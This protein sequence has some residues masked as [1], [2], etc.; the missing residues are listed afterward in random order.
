MK[1]PKVSVLISAYNEENYIGKCIGSLL[2]QTYKDMEIVVIDDGSRDKTLEIVKKYQSVRVVRQNH[3]GLGASRNTGARNARGDIIIF[4]DADLVYDKDYVKN[5]IKPIL[6]GK[7][8]GTCHMVEKVANADNIW[9]KNWGV[10]RLPEKLPKKLGT[11]RAVLKKEFLKVGGCPTD[12]GTFAD[13]LL[14]NK[15]GLADGVENAVCYHHNPTH[16]GEIFRH[17]A[18]IGSS[19]VLNKEARQRHAK[20]RVPLLII[21]IIALILII[22]LFITIL[23]STI[24][25]IIALLLLFGLWRAIRTNDAR[26]IYAAPVYKTVWFSGFAYGIAR[27]MIKNFGKMIQGKKTENY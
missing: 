22:I 4:A 16:L 9:A 24:G 12:K 11:F 23:F 3:L 14:C 8:I 20:K 15:L 6:E 17:V 10:T 13:A 5:L 25:L 26:M 27:Q 21:G 2:K 19:F 7:S 1:N 18:W